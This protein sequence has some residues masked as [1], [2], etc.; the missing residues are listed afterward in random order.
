MSSYDFD[1]LF[2]SILLQEM[3]QLILIKLLHTNQS[4]QGYTHELFTQLHQNAVLNPFLLFSGVY[5]KQVNCLGIGLP[6]GPTF[7]NIFL[8]HH[9]DIWLRNCPS[10]SPPALSTFSSYALVYVARSSKLTL[11]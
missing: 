10:D 9:E 5:Y 7:A 6:L 1:S 2:T 8:C 11:S 4:I 3:I